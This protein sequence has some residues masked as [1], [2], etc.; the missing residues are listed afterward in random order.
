MWK[1]LFTPLVDLLFN[2][3]KKSS[4]Y[5]TVNMC[6]WQTNKKDTVHGGTDF[7]IGDNCLDLFAYTHSRQYRLCIYVFNTVLLS[8]VPYYY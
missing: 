4:Q 6:P 2:L 8:V 7:T 5:N 1:L 3:H